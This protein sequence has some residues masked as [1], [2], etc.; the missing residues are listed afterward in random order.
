MPRKYLSSSSEIELPK[1]NRKKYIKSKIV[2]SDEDSSD[3]EY[4]KT[5]S[6][7]DEDLS[8]ESQTSNNKNLSRI[9]TR[10]SSVEE[11]SEKKIVTPSKEDTELSSS[12][13]DDIIIN[14]AENNF[15]P[16]PDVLIAEIASYNTAED[17]L[18]LLSLGFYTKSVI[19]HMNLDL[20]DRPISSIALDKVV[21]KLLLFKSLSI[22]L[23]YHRDEINVM[24]KMAH[25]ITSLVVSGLKISNLPWLKLCP[26][27]RL[28]VAFYGRFNLNP[29]KTFPKLEELTIDTFN[30]EG[31]DIEVNEKNKVRKLAIN[32]H[33]E[34]NLNFISRLSNLEELLLSTGNMG[35]DRNNQDENTMDLYLEKCEKLKTVGIYGFNV[36]SNLNFI[37]SLPLIESF[38]YFGEANFYDDDVEPII[39]KNKSLRKVDIKG[40]E[41]GE[42]NFSGCK[43]LEDLTLYCSAT[44]LDL[45]GTSLKCLELD[46]LSIDN[47]DFLSDCP[48]LLKFSYTNHT[49]HGEFDI[50]ALSHCD[51]LEILSIQLCHGSSF[52]GEESMLE[53]INL[54]HFNC[55]NVETDLSCLSNCVDIDTLGLGSVSIQDGT[56][57][58]S[59]LKNLS[60]L[61]RLSIYNCQ[62][63]NIHHISNCVN[64]EKLS[65]Q[66]DRTLS[67]LSGLAKLN[68]L[69]LDNCGQLISLKDL[70]NCTELKE[71]SI[72]GSPNLR[73]I[74]GIEKCT[75][76]RELLFDN[77][78]IRDI[79]KLEFCP[80]LKKITL[81]N[82]N[83][84]DISPLLKC[85]NL[86]TALLSDNNRIRNGEVLEKAR[87]VLL[88][89]S[90]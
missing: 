21:D 34:G 59:F 54:K 8:D 69:I 23:V 30:T 88:N 11:D 10:S 83:V 87:F 26:L 68:L 9:K 45:R 71:L 4:K 35:R 89:R 52:R 7:S 76:L 86:S 78:R 12:L 62:P 55:V 73:T 39:I 72:N 84:E 40:F 2:S 77:S 1:S 38:N 31:L 22:N 44:T 82:T 19:S 13:E 81:I 75:N 15:I 28:E 74:S 70:S 17:N 46:H 80:K 33:L 61:T 5:F 3:S 18:D 85:N 20:S 27:N 56:L 6:S 60:K 32:N 66:P 42:Y 51:K 90:I 37:N 53:L 49:N 79:S 29:F 25:K 64:L 36:L 50:T 41:S 58:L 43:N 63:K 14:I 67:F 65:I 24:S 48:E 16:L 57:D 47:L